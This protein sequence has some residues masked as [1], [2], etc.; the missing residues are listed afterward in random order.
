MV[1]RIRQHL[2]VSLWTLATSYLA[3]ALGLRPVSFASD[4]LFDACQ[5][6]IINNHNDDMVWGLV[7]LLLVGFGLPAE[8]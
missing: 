4:I 1:K 3:A 5:A 6:G 7:P 2:A 8:G